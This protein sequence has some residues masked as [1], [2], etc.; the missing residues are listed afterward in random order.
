[1]GKRVIDVWAQ[2]LIKQKFTWGIND[3]HQ[4]LLQ[5]VMLHNPAWND[6]QGFA[7]MQYSTWREANTVAKTLNLPEVFTKLGYVRRA[8]NRV[9]AGDIMVA[10]IKNRSYDLYIPVIFGQTV[11]C[12]DPSTKN[13]RMRHASEVDH[14]YEVYR[15]SECQQQ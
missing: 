14:S 2:N 9:E 4:M 10:S 3:C 8:V 12:A 1:M 6:E 11:L 15:R 5:F 13:I 7:K